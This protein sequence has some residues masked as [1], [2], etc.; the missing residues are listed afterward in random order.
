VLAGRSSRPYEIPVNRTAS[1]M[2]GD[3]GAVRRAFPQEAVPIGWEEL[4]KRRACGPV[5]DFAQVF[6]DQHVRERGMEIKVNTPSNP[7][8]R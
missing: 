1:F 8:C 4:E 3:H 6:A 7:R 2:Q 5:N